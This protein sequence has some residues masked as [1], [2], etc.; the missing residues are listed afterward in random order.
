[1]DESVC[2][3]QD[4]SFQT[5]MGRECALPV[6]MGMRWLEVSPAASEILGSSCASRSAQCYQY[7]TLIY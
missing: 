1:V 3:L 2:H 4:G 7:L 6:R 5:S